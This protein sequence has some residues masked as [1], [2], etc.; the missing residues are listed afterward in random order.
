MTAATAPVIELNIANATPADALF[1][2]CLTALFTDPACANFLAQF[3]AGDR[4]LRYDTVTGELYLI[5]ILNPDLTH[6]RN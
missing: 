4:A 1:F 2:R 6:Q 3:R 5:P